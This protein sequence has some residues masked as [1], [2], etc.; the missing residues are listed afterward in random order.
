M[1][2]LARDV[3]RPERL[4]VR[5][6]V[7]VECVALR[8][9]QLIWLNEKYFKEHAGERYNRQFLV[10]HILDSFAVISVTSA[11]MLQLPLGE[12][13]RTLFADRYGGTFGSFHGGSGR[14][15]SFRGLNGKGI[16]RTSLVSPNVD[17]QHSN[18]LLP[19]REAMKEAVYSEICQK[20]LPRG[21]IPVLA[22]ISCGFDYNFSTDVG[23]EPCAV[24]VRP[25]FIRPAHFERAIFFGDA[26]YVGSQQYL[27]AE[28]VGDAVRKALLN[29]EWNLLPETMFAALSC[30]IGAARA[31]RLW[32]GRLLSSNVSTSGALVDFG[33]FRTIPSWNRHVGLTGELFGTELNQLRRAYLSVSFYFTKFGGD[34]RQYVDTSKFLEDLRKREHEAFLQTCCNGLGARSEDEQAAIGPLLVGLFDEAQSRSIGEDS[35]THSEIA[36][37]LELPSLPGKIKGAASQLV[38]MICRLDLAG[39]GVTIERARNFFA[40]RSHFRYGDMD[41]RAANTI[42]ECRSAKDVSGIVADF[43]DSTVDAYRSTSGGGSKPA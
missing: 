26:G 20:E 8:R 1:I 18:G 16:G 3:L 5:A 39:S 42:E 36:D 43:I 21:A 34:L 4:G 10:R 27:D 22:I 25:D 12:P 13:S 28:R 15:G 2:K 6:V 23:P 9:A 31:L 32:P 33:S 35:E 37:L 19:L 11:K 40:T 14:A 17:R 41:T 29:P 38:E 7:D 24:L 30:Q